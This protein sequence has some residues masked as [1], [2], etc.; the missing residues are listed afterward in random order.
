MI[1]KSGLTRGMNEMYSRD[2]FPP[3]KTL[4]TSA[5]HSLSTL[6]AQSFSS[7]TYNYDI[8][9]QERCA[10]QGKRTDLVREE[11]IEVHSTKY[12]QY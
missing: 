6:P 11:A 12:S 1:M 3:N 10:M 4:A 5:V 2:T 8:P 9:C 7:S